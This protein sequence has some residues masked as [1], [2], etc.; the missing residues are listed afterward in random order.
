MP[1]YKIVE[2]PYYCDGALGVGLYPSL[3]FHKGDI[4]VVDSINDTDE[5][6]DVRA[7]VDDDRWGEWD[8][9]APECLAPYSPVDEDY[10]PDGLTPIEGDEVI[11]RLVYQGDEV[12]EGI[13][14]YISSA[15]SIFVTVT[16]G[17]EGNIGDHRRC[18][19]KT[20]I[21]KSAGAGMAVPEPLAEWERELLAA[22][23]K[24]LLELTR[25]E[26][27]QVILQTSGCYD[28][29]GTT[30]HA[31]AKALLPPKMVTVT[32]TV[33][34]ATQAK[35]GVLINTTR[36]GDSAYNKLKEALNSL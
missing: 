20:R 33:G 19:H 32:L 4:V 27:D 12:V 29:P 30:V 13:V 11:G 25:E 26:L 8:Y 24:F 14:T 18:V 36:D 21:L 6:G 5:D 31:K 2:E 23:G 9:I 17:P 1:K 16:E 10:T 15:G 34:E 35:A 3:S 7:T 22:N 28:A